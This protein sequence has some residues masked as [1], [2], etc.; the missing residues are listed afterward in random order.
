MKI[1]KETIRM[2]ILV[3]L[4]IIAGAI[5]GYYIYNN[6]D[7]ETLMNFFNSNPLRPI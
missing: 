3:V 1:K 2:A 6:V 5:T 4:T 7:P